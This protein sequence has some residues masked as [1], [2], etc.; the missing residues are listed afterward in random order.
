MSSDNFEKVSDINLLQAIKSTVLGFWTERKNNYFPGPLPVS[1][2]RKNLYKLLQYPYLI[3]MKSDGIRYFLIAYNGQSYLID[4]SFNVYITKQ[5]FKKDIYGSSSD[6]S[7]G[8]LFDGEMVKNSDNKLVYVIHDCVCSFG[9]SISSENLDE[10]YENV[11]HIL[12]SFWSNE[13]SSFKLETKKFYTFSEIDNLIEDIN[14]MEH[15]TDGLIFTP[16]TLPIGCQQ[17]F[18]LYKWKACENHTFD[19]KITDDR[20]SYYAFV[21]AGQAD[22]LFASIEK[23]SKEGSI[24]KELLLKNCPE[25]K[26]NSIVECSYDSG[27]ESFNPLKLRSDKSNPNSLYT[28]EKTLLNI[29]ENITLDEMC[30]LI[31]KS[32]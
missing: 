20:D 4:R 2:E 5:N 8:L 17:Q 16:I 22:K 27:K 6:K 13:N 32:K 15:K 9:R 25:Y 11:K 30:K 18:S 12:S 31:K 1:L 24:F 26:S 28:V 3:C 21:S 23:T 19:F 14:K 10:R 29:E 7:C